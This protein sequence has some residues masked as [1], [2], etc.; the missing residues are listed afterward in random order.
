MKAMIA[1]VLIKT[2]PGTAL[3]VA[4]AVAGITGVRWASVITGPYDI[5]AGVKVSDGQALGTLVVEGIHHI[6]GVIDT[7]T[8][9]LVSYHPSE[10]ISYEVGGAP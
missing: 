5:I 10:D 9:V 3:V 6:E 4:E 8:G 2:E 7:T 1:Y